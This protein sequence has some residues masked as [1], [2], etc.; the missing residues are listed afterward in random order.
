MSKKTI[1]IGASVVVVIAAVIIIMNMNNKKSTAIEVETATVKRENIIQTVNANG[2][3]Q[4]V[5]QVKI[6][7]DVSAK[8]MR[9]G[10]K[11]GDWVEK[12]D[13]LIEL[14][15]ERYLAAVESAEANVNSAEANAKLAEENMLKTAKDNKRAQELFAKQLESQAN[16]DAAEAAYKVEKA[17]YES[18]L[19]LVE[20][21]KASLKQNRDS[22][23]K[24]TIYAPMSGTIS[25]LNKEVGEIALG[26]QFQEDVIMIVSNLAGMEARVDVDENDI[27]SITVGD[28]AKIE[29]DAIPNLV[30][31]GEVT[32]IASSAK[33]SGQ[34]STDQKTDFEVK[35]GVT[36]IYKKQN[37]ESQQATNGHATKGDI[38][39]PALDPMADLRPGMTATS[40]I[41][42][43]SHENTLVIPIQCV[44]VRTVD[45]LKK[46]ETK[47]EKDGDE[48]GEKNEIKYNADKDGFVEIVFVIRDKRAYAMPVKTG[49]QSE[50]HIEILDG[51]NENDVV[52]SGNYRAISKD[53]Y[54]DAEVTVR[55]KTEEI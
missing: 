43:E 45:Q 23:A 31:R 33:V 52:V 4:P 15:R 49:I 51:L 3:I 32:D 27:V 13:F 19:E 41:M 53:L 28:S 5:T 30:F 39:I 50:T 47:K 16:V 35:I 17:R 22:L 38:R 37:E 14:D 8:I 2:R 20:Q 24:T 48:N 10:V 46:H 54:N 9:L 1:I 26:S 11:E 6:S 55:N 44:A 21:A 34:G 29:V 42:V 12:G 18:A 7:A 36:G 40:D 25:T